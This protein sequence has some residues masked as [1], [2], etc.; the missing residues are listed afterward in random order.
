MDARKTLERTA[1]GLEGR[2]W[3]LALWKSFSRKLDKGRV[4]EKEGQR[5]NMYDYEQNLEFISGDF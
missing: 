4:N 2:G 3:L 1:K 5:E